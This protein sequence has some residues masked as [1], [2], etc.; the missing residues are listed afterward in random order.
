ME[1]DLEKLKMKEIQIEVDRHSRILRRA[2]E[3]AG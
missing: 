1:L 3:L 2:E